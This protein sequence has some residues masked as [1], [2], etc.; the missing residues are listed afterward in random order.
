VSFFA[1]L[2]GFVWN[3]P[4]VSKLFKFLTPD[5]HHPISSSKAPERFQNVFDFESVSIH[6][7]VLDPEFNLPVDLVFELGW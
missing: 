6:L 2:V 5:T 1:F 3:S 7:G 4:E